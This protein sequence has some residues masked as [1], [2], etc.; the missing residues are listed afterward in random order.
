MDAELAV[1]PATASRSRGSEAVVLHLMSAG[2]RYARTDVPGVPGR[3]RRDAAASG[4]SRRFVFV[5]IRSAPVELASA[6]PATG[7]AP[8][9]SGIVERC[10]GGIPQSFGRGSDRRRGWLAAACGVS[11]LRGFQQAA[12]RWLS[13]RA[14]PGGAGTGAL[15]TVERRFRYRVGV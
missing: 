15:C 7:V 6:A 8:G 14:E 4:E 1:D 5:C 13:S 12:W 2:L 10:A 11:H 3:N 9:P